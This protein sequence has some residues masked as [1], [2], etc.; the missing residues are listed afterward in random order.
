MTVSV[1][2]AGSD[3][4][5]DPPYFFQEGSV[6]G[7]CCSCYGVVVARPDG[8][9]FRLEPHQRPLACDPSEDRLYVQE[10]KSNEED[11]AA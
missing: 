1:P 3:V 11:R 5:C 6:H 2:C 10:Q 7:V 8:S 9:G 4:W